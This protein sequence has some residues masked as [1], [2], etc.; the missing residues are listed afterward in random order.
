[1]DRTIL[2]AATALL[3][4]AAAG[5][6]WAGPVTTS[7]SCSDRPALYEQMRGDSGIAIISQNFESSFDQY[8]AQAADDFKVAD[9]TWFIREVDVVGN[10]F[11]SA[12]VARDETVVF[13]ENA[14]GLP[15]AEIARYAIDGF[16]NSF[17]S[18]CIPLKDGLLLR[19]GRYWISVI[20]NMNYSTAGQW[21]WENSTRRVFIPSAWRNPGGGFGVC[22]T[23]TAENICVPNGQGDH[24]FT[25]R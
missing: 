23:W 7:P 8:D 16:D 20:A 6:A 12:G 5:A 18:F 14:H 9:T 25:L 1:M 19:K 13:Y 15:G 21:G 2:L 3:G 10:Y 17:G 22:R 11:D 4:L 24:L